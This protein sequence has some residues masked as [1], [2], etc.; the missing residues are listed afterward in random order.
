MRNI[1]HASGPDLATHRG[2]AEHRR[3]RARG[4]ADDDVLR[5]QRLQQHGVDN[6]ITDEG[7]EGQPH[8][9]RVD[10]H[11]QQRA[12]CCE[13]HCGEQQGL[14]GGELARGARD[15]RPCAASC[16]SICCST[17]QLK[18]AAAAATSQMPTVAAIAVPQSGRPGRR[19]QHADDRAEDDQLDDARL[20]QR[21]ELPEPR[22]QR[23]A[24]RGWTDDGIGH[25]NGAEP[26]ILRSGVCRHGGVAAGTLA[27]PRPRLR[28]TRQHDRQQDHQRARP[29]RYGRGRQQAASPARR[30]TALSR[31]ATAATATSSRAQRRP[32]WRRTAPQPPGQQTERQ[33]DDQPPRRGGSRG[34]PSAP[35]TAGSRPRRPSRVRAAAGSQQRNPSRATNCP[36]RSGSHGRPAP[37]S[38]C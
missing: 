13:Q 4:A 11:P 30:W 9:Q 7:G 8:R 5:R 15:A 34:S 29:L 3:H 36:G 2:P 25:R 27:P 14:R 21:M 35:Q 28:R 23:H 24:G 22:D 32:L 19:Q 18:A 20:G 16:E 17:R 10:G 31:T 12:A 26:W 38:W 37:H 1:T 33:E 6:R